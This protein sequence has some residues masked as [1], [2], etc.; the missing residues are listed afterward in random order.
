MPSDY[1]P[2][3]YQISSEPSRQLKVVLD[4]F[5]LLKTWDLEALPQLS[6]PHFTQATLP[7]SLGLP[8][9]TK[10]EDIDFLHSFR[11]SLKGAPLEVCNIRK[12]SFL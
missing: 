11:D 3:I 12:H 5:N 6:A 4:Y 9:R 2:P 10:E 8:V 1:K 7:A